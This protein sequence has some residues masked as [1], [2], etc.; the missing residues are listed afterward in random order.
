[1][2]AS[3][4][5]RFPQL[6]KSF[7]IRLRGNVAGVWPIMTIRVSGLSAAMRVPDRAGPVIALSWDITWRRK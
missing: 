3:A 4:E 6:V 5:A 1:M 7:T 2:T